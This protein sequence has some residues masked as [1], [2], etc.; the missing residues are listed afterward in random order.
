MEE[1][2]IK[3]SEFTPLLH[4]AQSGDK[5]AEAEF[6]NLIH[7]ELHRLA[8]SHLRRERRGHT[9]QPTALVNE[10]YMSLKNLRNPQ[11]NNRSH[12]LAMASRAM[13]NILIDYAR[14]RNAHKGPG[15]H[16]HLDIPPGLASPEIRLD[17]VL[18][19]DAAL[20]KLEMLSTRQAT[21]VQMRFFGGMTEQEIATELGV[22][23]KTVMRAW[24]AGRAFLQGV[25]TAP[26]P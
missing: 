12:F 15:P 4:R 2:D 13:R 23:E 1:K 18:Q 24:A 5:A 8:G 9:L 26:M 16:N 17:D 14:K 21:V 25:L 10:A 19:I 20:Q 11:W 6:L 7:S 3:K 22:N